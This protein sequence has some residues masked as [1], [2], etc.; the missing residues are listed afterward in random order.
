MTPIRLE[1]QAEPRLTFKDKISYGGHY[2]GHRFNEAVPLSSCEITDYMLTDF[3][4]CSVPT[5]FSHHWLGLTDQ[6]RISQP[7]K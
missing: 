4:Y 5:H 7:S 6:R 2:V 3:S 1:A